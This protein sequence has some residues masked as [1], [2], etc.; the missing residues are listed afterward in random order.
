[1]LR[2]YQHFG[3]QRD[4]F[5]DTSDPQFYL[6]LPTVRRS[7]RRVLTAVNE[8]RGLTVVIGPPGS[9]K[10]SLSSNVEQALLSDDSVVMGK[11][12]DPGFANDVEFLLSIGRVFG[13]D[14][15]SRSSSVLKNAIKNFL[16]DTAIVEKKTVVLL[17]DEA[18]NLTADGLETLRLLLNFQI[19]EKKLLNLVL[20]GEEELAQFI[21]GRENFSDR[22][23]TYVRLDALDAAASIA[24]VEHRLGKAG[25][26]PLVEVLTPNALEYAVDA[27]DGLARRLTNV[28]RCAMIEAA[29]RGAEVVNVDHVI[30]ALRARGMKTSAFPAPAPLPVAVPLPVPPAVSAPQAAAVLAA[31]SVSGEIDVKE[32][33]RVGG[34]TFFSRILAWF[35]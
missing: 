32:P 3:L 10:T 5:L 34:P 7:I 16:F 31:P 12:L 28:V 24:L 30:A 35:P 21:A 25:K 4:P 6:E 20:F 23:D 18:Q 26:L 22:V 33:A 15:K 17:I 13:L 9:G 27:A 11:I 1:M 14:L 8:S 29:D 2:Y 19:P